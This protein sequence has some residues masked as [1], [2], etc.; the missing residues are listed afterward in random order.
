MSRITVSALHVT[1]GSEESGHLLRHEL[2]GLAGVD[3]LDYLVEPTGYEWTP[4]ITS[5][6]ALI[7]LIY[8]AMLSVKPLH[9]EG[10]LTDELLFKVRHDVMPL[11]AARDSR[12]TP[13]EITVNDTAG[14][15]YV[16]ERT[17]VGTGYSGGIDSFAAL[18]LYSEK[19]APASH[20]VSHL[21]L[22][23]NK[24][25]RVGRIDA[26]LAAR[27]HEFSDA[28]GY[29]LTKVSSNIEK[30]IDT[31][32]DL[33]KAGSYQQTHSL[34]SA[35]S[36]YV[37]AGNLRRYIYSGGYDYQLVTTKETGDIAY[38]D[39][40]L[41]PLLSTSAFQLVSGCAGM[42]RVDKTVLIAERE[43]AQKYLHVCIRRSGALENESENPKRGSAE[44]INCSDCWKC[45]RTMLTLEV[46]GSL[47]RFSRI[48]DLAFF[49]AN[50]RLIARKL[51]RKGARGDLLA[52][53][54]LEFAESNG[55]L[56]AFLKRR[57]ER[58][59]SSAP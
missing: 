46:A 35:A 23:G 6:H 16:S 52:T 8:P 54:A 12:L 18:E 36:A 45:A 22:F 58:E 2:D 26:E 4:V 41:M 59:N 42:R 3:R 11:L 9:F 33:K 34:R 50:R 17:D 19:Y 56:E 14:A 47:H 48:F 27:A 53:E 24:Y 37:L 44:F 55:G 31:V 43:D 5:D 51:R 21:A 30:V 15:D 7:A 38:V 57:L 28:M 49:D 32:E 1:S 29:P 10:V 20:R 13:V 25:E 39:P 40:M